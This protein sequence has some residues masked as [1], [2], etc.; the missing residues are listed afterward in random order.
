M[1]DLMRTYA[2]LPMSFADA[3]LVCMSEVYD[4]SRV[5]TVDSDFRVCQRRGSEAI[6]V[7]MPEG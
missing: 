3:Y 7:M 5:F 1:N 2:D 6:P 4:E